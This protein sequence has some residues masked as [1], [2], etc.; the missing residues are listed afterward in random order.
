MR[1][2][3][4]AVGRMRASPEREMADDYLGRFERLGRSLGL[5]PAEV[6]EVEARQGG[7]AAAEAGLLRGAVPEGAVLAVLDERGE[8]LSSREFAQ[9]LARWRDEGRAAAAFAV[10]GADGLDPGL[11]A[12]AR[13]VLGF[14]RMAWPHM[15]AR[16]MLAEQIYR[17]ASILAGTPYHRE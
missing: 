3:I 4:C 6:R 15:L 2:R 7:G 12:D 9:T 11:R 10:G 16:V 14:G 1:I 5:G 8:A 17:A 13:L